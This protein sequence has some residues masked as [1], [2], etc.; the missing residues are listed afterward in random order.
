MLVVSLRGVKSNRKHGLSYLIIL[1]T[2]LWSQ[3]TLRNGREELNFFFH[4]FFLVILDSCNQSFFR[5][6]NQNLRRASPPLSCGSS[7]RALNIGYAK[8]KEN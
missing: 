6:L 1:K 5:G 3:G 4:F 2:D 7:P 8:L